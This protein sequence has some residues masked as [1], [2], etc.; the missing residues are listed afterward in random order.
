VLRHLDVGVLC[1]YSEGLSNAVL[2]YQACGLPVVCTNVGGN[3][4]LIE[5]GK[6]GFFVRPG[7]VDALGQRL[8]HLLRH[9]DEARAMGRQGQA[10]VR[11]FSLSAMVEHHMHLY[12][13]LANGSVAC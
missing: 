3:L 12:E 8:I 1:S 5:E 11:R 6:T 9:A 2:E 10:A 4:E 7:D 13:T